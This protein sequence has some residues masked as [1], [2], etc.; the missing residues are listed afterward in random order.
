MKRAFLDAVYTIRDEA[1][2]GVI[3]DR[4]ERGDIDGAFEAA[5]V[6]L[7]KFRGLEKTYQEGYEA[8]GN[9][10]ARAVPATTAPDGYRAV[11]QFDVRNPNAEQW[12][13]YS[14]SRLVTNITDDQRDAIRNFLQASLSRG[15]N[16]R[17]AALDLVGR[18]NP[19]T[20]RREGGII[21]LTAQQELWSRNYRDEL[22]SLDAGALRRSLRDMR[23]DATFR[24]AIYDGKPLTADMIGKMVTAYRNRALRLRAETIGRTETIASL[25]AAQDEAFRQAIADGAIDSTALT[26]IWRTARD[27]RVRATHA[28]MNGQRVANGKPFQS[29]SGA[30]LR[31]PGDPLAPASETINCRCWREPKVDFLAAAVEEEA[32]LRKGTPGVRARGVVDAGRVFKQWV[33]GSMIGS[34]GEQAALAIGNQA[35]LAA[36]AGKIATKTKLEF[37]NPGV[38]KLDGIERKIAQG[39]APAA[40]SDAVRGGFDVRTPAQADLIVKDLASEFE[41]IDEGW[42][43]TPAGYF[44]R[45]VIVRFPDG[46]MGE[47]QFWP[48]GMLEA[49]DGAGG[50]H[51]LYEEWRL[52]PQDSARASELT[53]EMIRLY[54]GVAK[55]LPPSWNAVKGSFGKSG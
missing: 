5:G 20:R 41:I 48:P 23:F 8:A 3:A 49:K 51:L 30:T 17:A 31:Y 12:L 21:G 42:R 18:I 10:T 24:R 47:I 6:D 4:L 29:P 15:D 9:Y 50:G 11:F 39:R 53:R 1:Q 36:V 26:W 25:H 28:A 27:E 35:R 33:A 54:D 22:L 37:A 16:P 45:K 46:Q 40:I 34:A 43:R 52:L 38:K 14:S 19:L 7:N 2:I 55:E 44:D 32:L 13:L